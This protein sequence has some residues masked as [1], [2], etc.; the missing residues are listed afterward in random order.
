[1]IMDHWTTHTDGEGDEATEVH[2]IA[3]ELLTVEVS[4]QKNHTLWTAS[5]MATITADVIG[6]QTYHSDF[7]EARVLVMKKAAELLEADGR[8]LASTMLAMGHKP[9]ES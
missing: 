6:R 1:M 9:T 2:Q 7:E 3:M 4:K 8:V 5:V